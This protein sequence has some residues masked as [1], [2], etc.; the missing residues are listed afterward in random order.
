MKKIFTILVAA[1]SVTIAS[2]QSKGS[3][4]HD[5]KSSSR[6]VILGQSN[7]TVYKNNTASYGSSSFSIKE[8]DAQVKRINREFDQKINAVQ[9]DRHLRFY[10]KSRQIK[11]LERQRDEQIRDVQQRF[12]RDQRD[13]RYD[14]RKW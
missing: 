7:S 8:R 14:N 1:A 4:G 12:S 10:E 9:R 6:D 5:E 11:M 2:A 3:W 13:S